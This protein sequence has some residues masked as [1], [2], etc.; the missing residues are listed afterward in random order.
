MQS[1]FTAKI[2]ICRLRSSHYSKGHPSSTT[3]ITFSVCNACEYSRHRIMKS[4]K[5]VFISC[6]HRKLKE[7]KQTLPKKQI[8]LELCLKPIQSYGSR[9]HNFYNI[10]KRN[11]NFRFSFYR[12]FF[13]E[14]L[15]RKNYVKNVGI[16]NDKYF[17]KNITVSSRFPSHTKF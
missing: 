1:D 4:L 8:R 2:K 17:L 11:F 12:Q 3:Q 5:I 9:M 13:D 7:A 14:E 6:R 15:T 16:S 10:K